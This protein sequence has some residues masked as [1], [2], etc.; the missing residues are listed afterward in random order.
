MQTS[1]SRSICSALLRWSLGWGGGGDTVLKQGSPFLSLS[2][3]L[4][5]ALL[6][7]LTNAFLNE[8][9]R[10]QLPVR[11]L[12]FT[13]CPIDKRNLISEPTQKARCAL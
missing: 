8:V 6:N 11:R 7:T 10:G 2:L 5:G 12:D 3:E 4:P 9:P 1:L 13:D